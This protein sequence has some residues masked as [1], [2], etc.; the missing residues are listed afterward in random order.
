MRTALQDRLTDRDLN[1]A[2]ALLDRASLTDVVAGL[3]ELDETERA[4]AFRLLDKPTAA[5]VFEYLTPADQRRLLLAL[6]NS[7]AA[8]IFESL[9]TDDQVELLDELPAAVAK[10]LVAE[11][12]P[13]DRTASRRSWPTR[14]VR[15]GAT[16]TPGSSRSRPTTPS[17]TR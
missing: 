13:D 15:S 14:P 12:A 10:Q 1:G 4:L 5:M 3:R 7:D 2:K 6:S 9:P 11:L 8:A 16:P 17:R